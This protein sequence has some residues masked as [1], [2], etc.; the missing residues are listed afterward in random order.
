[1]LAAGVGKHIRYPLELA[2]KNQSSL[3][4]LRILLSADNRITSVTASRYTPKQLAIALTKPEI[5]TN[6]DWQAI[7]EGDK[8]KPHTVIIP[9]GIYNEMADS[10]IFVEYTIDGLFD[11]GDN[12]DPLI[13]C[14]IL[15]PVI[16]KYTAPKK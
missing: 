7:F 6:V 10:S 5:Y 13:G 14:S 9:V 12:N 3:F 16:T 4:S 15:K 11:F 2:S 1:M 8:D